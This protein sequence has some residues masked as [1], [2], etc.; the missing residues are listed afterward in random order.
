[1]NIVKNLKMCLKET[2]VSWIISSMSLKAFLQSDSI[3]LSHLTAAFSKKKIILDI[4]W[5]LKIILCSWGKVL[6][7]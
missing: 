6:K 7:S 2:D 1:M 4:N 3:L 5:L